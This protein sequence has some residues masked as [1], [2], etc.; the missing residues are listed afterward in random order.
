MRAKRTLIAAALAA[1]AAVLAALFQARTGG[2][3]WGAKPGADALARHARDLTDR[4]IRIVWARDDGEKDDLY[5]VGDRLSL[6]GFDSR[7]ER[8]ERVLA[9]GP[10]NVTRP[11]FSPDGETVFFS[12]KSDGWIYRVPWEGGPVDRFARG[13]ALDAWRDPESGQD[14]VLSGRG[15]PDHPRL[16]TRIDRIRID[17]PS[18]RDP[19]CDDFTINE[20]NFQLSRS[21]RFASAD[22]MGRGMGVLDLREDTFDA[23][24]GGC[25]PSLA[26]DDSGLFWRMATGHRELILDGPG[27][28]RRIPLVNA[29]GIDGYEVFHPR[30]SND[31]R[32]LVLSG[33]YKEGFGFNRLGF[34]GPAVDIYLG[35]FDEDF[36]RIERWARITRTESADFHPDAW[37]A[38]PDR[39]GR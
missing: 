8:G 35:R 30:W 3:Q 5:A 38:P 4:A 21:G 2:F 9:P 12:D 6:V 34:G 1:A 10:R 22:V 27:G 29:P 16:H 17:D 15:H 37:I 19:V 23:R 24:G 26:P 28:E 7:D 13:R 31:P 18:V 32:F 14:W 20:N 39:P 25:W 11:L 36:T 33:P